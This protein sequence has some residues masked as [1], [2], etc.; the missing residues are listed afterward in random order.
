MREQRHVQ[1]HRQRREQR[2]VA[3]QILRHAG[4][5]QFGNTSIVVFG[6]AVALAQG[7]HPGAVLHHG[8]G[9]GRIQRHMR[10]EPARGAAE[11]VGDV[12]IK[13]GLN[14]GL[15]FQ[16]QRIDAGLERRQAKGAVAEHKA[17]RHLCAAKARHLAGA[18]AEHRPGQIDDGVD[19]HG[20]DDL[21]LQAM[22]FRL[23]REGRDGG[24]RKIAGQQ[25]GEGGIVGQGAGQDFRIQVQLGIGQQHRT[26][27]AGSGPCRHWPGC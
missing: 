21:A 16:V 13:P 25:R 4:L 5:R 9:N 18:Q 14:R 11:L 8:V 1:R 19:Q 7:F 22:A 10:Q 24:G 26:V 15:H 3:R 17:A 2:H 23:L 20:G 27:P 12:A 6:Q